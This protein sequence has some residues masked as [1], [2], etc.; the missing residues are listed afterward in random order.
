MGNLIN[1]SQNRYDSGHV[2][3]QTNTHDST[4][5]EVSEADRVWEER[6]LSGMPVEE[7]N[8]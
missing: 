5:T 7:D 8:G 3:T 4:D 6:V 1:M 2:F